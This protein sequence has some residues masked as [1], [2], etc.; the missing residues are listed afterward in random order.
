MNIIFMIKALMLKI[1]ELNQDQS[2]ITL[3]CWSS[4][5]NKHQVNKMTFNLKA[6]IYKMEF[7]NNWKSQIIY[8]HIKI[9]NK[10]KS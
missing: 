6:I 4:I 3:K 2:L 10:N 8:S 5:R 1:I 7:I 9:N